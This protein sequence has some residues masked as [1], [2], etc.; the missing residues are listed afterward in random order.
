LL[1]SILLK[2]RMHNYN[3]GVVDPLYD[4]FGIEL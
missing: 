2:R 4:V 1:F 3:F